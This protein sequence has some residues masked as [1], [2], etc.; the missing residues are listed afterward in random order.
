MQNTLTIIIVISLTSIINQISKLPVD[1][2]QHG[3]SRR[4]DKKLKSVVY[5]QFTKEPSF[6]GGNPAW[7]R[8]MSKNLDYRY[9]SFE[10]DAQTISRAR[11]IVEK[12]GDLSSIS[13]KNK[14][15]SESW[16]ALDSAFVQLLKSSGKWQPAECN[17]E[18]VAAY[19]EKL[20]QIDLT[21]LD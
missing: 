16:S 17:G 19:F 12:S 18:Q 15:S 6:P 8:F 21:Q 14:S 5:T 20:L 7:V 9:K 11:F 3:C 13:I 4:Y 2:V 10:M 1:S